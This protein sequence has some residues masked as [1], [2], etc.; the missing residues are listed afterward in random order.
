MAR[1]GFPSFAGSWSCMFGRS[2]LTPYNLRCAA[3]LIPEPPDS[4]TPA[5]RASLSGDSTGRTIHGIRTVAMPAR[6]FTI[7]LS[8]LLAKVRRYDADQEH[9]L[10]AKAEKLVPEML[11]VSGK[12]TAAQVE[13][14]DKALAEGLTLDD[15]AHDYSYLTD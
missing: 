7:H 14:L 12:L 6:R 15:I 11:R 3:R 10:K 4:P 1:T 8:D 13:I 5:R 9:A 2:M